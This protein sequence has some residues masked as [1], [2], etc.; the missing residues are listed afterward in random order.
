MQ[1][2]IA[3]LL[4]FLDM[5]VVIHEVKG[6]QSVMNSSSLWEFSQHLEIGSEFNSLSF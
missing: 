3:K 4:R 5:K 6:I 1:K 2:L